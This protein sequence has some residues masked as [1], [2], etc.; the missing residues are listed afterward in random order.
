MRQIALVAHEEDRH[1]FGA[2]QILGTFTKKTK[3][4]KTDREPN[5]GKL[6]K[7]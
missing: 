6:S 4:T 3:R 1:L 2:L 7:H 5:I